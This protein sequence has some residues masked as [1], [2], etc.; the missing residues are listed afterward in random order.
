[1]ERTYFCSCKMEKSQKF[2]VKCKIISNVKWAFSWL[3]NGNSLVPEGGPV[4]VKCPLSLGIF[5][6]STPPRGLK[7]TRWSCKSMRH[8]SKFGS[9]CVPLPLGAS[10]GKWHTLQNKHLVI[11]N[12]SGNVL[13]KIVEK[14][15]G[16]LTH[17]G[18]GFGPTSI[19]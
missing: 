5:L 2:T 4:C 10:G 7:N 8:L 11:L 3:L 6:R 14:V 12:T 16:H 13:V 18:C 1:M 19:D 9:K 15:R 17:T